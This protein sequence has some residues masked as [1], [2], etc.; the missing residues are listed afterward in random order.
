MKCVILNVCYINIEKEKIIV[1]WAIFLTFFKVGLFTI[2]G[3]YAMLPILQQA[4]VN[5]CWMTDDECLDVI[6]L[7]NGLPGPIVV[8]AATFMGY[9]LKGVSGALTAVIGAILPS[10]I[11]IILIESLFSAMMGQVYVQYFFAGARAGVCA[12][13]LYSMV[14]LGRA[15]R[16][17]LWYNATL[18]IAAFVAVG[19]L[20]V[21]HIFAILAAALVGITG[22]AYRDKKRGDDENGSSSF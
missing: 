21:H 17:G 5:K 8:N 13:L 2:G 18:A 4:F 7:I 20:G 19:F 1:L 3:G 9:K 16:L 14:R 12:L 6:A 15:A 22:C 11:I 10:L